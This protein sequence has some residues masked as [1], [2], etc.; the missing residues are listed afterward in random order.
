MNKIDW[1]RKL[2]S[3]KFWVAVAAL[4]TGI[5]S[6]I[7]K[8]T[9]DAQTISSLILMLGSVIAYCIGEGIADAANANAEPK[10]TVIYV[11]SDDMFEEQEAKAEAEAQEQTEDQEGGEA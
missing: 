7:A 2:S 1:V 8:P 10:P 9:T 11:P 6:F 3:R 5:I 4:V